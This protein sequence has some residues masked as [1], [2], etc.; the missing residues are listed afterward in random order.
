MLSRRLLVPLVAVP[1]AV[2][3]VLTGTGAATAADTSADTGSVVLGAPAPLDAAQ[4]A[5]T[6]ALPNAS[7]VKTVG[8]PVHW[9][10]TDLAAS[11]KSFSTCTS[12]YFVATLTNTTYAKQPIKRNGALLG[13]IPARSRI[14]ICAEGS[15]A[16]TRS[17]VLG[18]NT[19][20][21]LAL[22]YR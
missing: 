12:A 20:S 3:T 7:I 17:F 18:K 11:R 8:R 21:K 9:N 4:P 2:G 5:T 22:H 14:G 13:T 6:A 1:F 16:F 19:N 10:K 15:S